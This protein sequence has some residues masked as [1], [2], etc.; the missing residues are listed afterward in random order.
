[1]TGVPSN[2][3]IATPKFFNQQLLAIVLVRVQKLERFQNKKRYARRKSSICPLGSSSAVV[4]VH[5]TSKMI[6][7]FRWSA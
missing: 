2:L 3:S 5:D 6:L 7:C 1:L 4:H